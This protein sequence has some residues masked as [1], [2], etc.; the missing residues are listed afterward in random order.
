MF[1]NFSFA[2]DRT[3]FVGPCSILLERSAFTTENLFGEIIRDV[4]RVDPYGETFT[5]YIFRSQETLEVYLTLYYAN[6]GRIFSYLW[7]QKGLRT[8][9]R[10]EGNLFNQQ[11]WVQMHQLDS[12]LTATLGTNLKEE[13]FITVRNGSDSVTIEKVRIKRRWLLS[14]ITVIQVY[15]F[16]KRDQSSQH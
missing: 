7:D 9:F 6:D 16:T 5:R 4:V 12:T 15:H 2:V 10:R 13:Q 11:T 14:T 8:D 1:M 3:P